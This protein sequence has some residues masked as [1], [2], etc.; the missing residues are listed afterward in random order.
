MKGPPPPAPPPGPEASLKQECPPLPAAMSDL[1][2]ALI[3]NHDQVAALYHD[4][5]ASHSRLIQAATE[6]ERTAWSWYCQAL[7][8]LQGRGGEKQ[9]GGRCNGVRPAAPTR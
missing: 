6:W 9:E 2:A 3:G 5:R 1:W 4:C 8:Q 7:E